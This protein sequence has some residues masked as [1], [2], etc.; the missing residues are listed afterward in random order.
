MTRVRCLLVPAMALLLAATQ[1]SDASA[2]QRRGRGFYGRGS[3]LLRLLTNE[4]VQEEL[5]LSDDQIAKVKEASDKIFAE[6]REKYSGLRDMDRAARQAKMDE[7]SKQTDEKGY[8]ELKDV[9][10]QEQFIRLL[11]VNLQIRGAVYGL[12]NERVA[13]RLELSDNQK[14]KIAELAKAT[15]AKTSKLY[16]GLADLSSE[17]R[18]AKFGELR[19]K[20]AKIRAAANTKAIATLKGDQK[21]AYEKMLGDKFEL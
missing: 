10:E 13:E 20:M 3:S 2:Q 4:K 18:R 21:E 19:E 12:G 9:I 16:T 11:Q 1:F 8:E 6:M 15:Q 5:D 7:L 14:D 17:E